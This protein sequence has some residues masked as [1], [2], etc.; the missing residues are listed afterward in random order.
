MMRERLY[1]A[2]VCD[3]LDSLGLRHQSPRVELI[4]MT[5]QGLLVGRCKTTLWADMF[6]EDPRPY[7][8]ELRA[9]DECQPDDVLIAAAG[10]SLR[11]GV[12]GELLATAAR[13]RGCCGAVVDG[14]VRD[15]A[16]LSD[17]GFPVF[18]RG[19]S[20]YDSRDRQRVIDIDVPVQIDGVRFGPGDLVFADVDGVVVVPREAEH[21][22]IQRAWAKVHAENATRDAI[23]GGMKA[24]E[25]WN[26]FGVL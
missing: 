18:A 2:V 9:V 16:R 26:R 1:A 24:G 13:N 23:R 15:L 22:A 3:A 4:P 7:D 11:S 10:G 12:W 21:E 17:M 6:H 5:V 8:L 14:A 25:A 19:R 20:I